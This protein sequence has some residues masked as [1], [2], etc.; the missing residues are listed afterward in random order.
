MKKQNDFKMWERAAVLQ[1]A[2]NLEAYNAG[3]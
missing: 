2:D 1:Y 3:T